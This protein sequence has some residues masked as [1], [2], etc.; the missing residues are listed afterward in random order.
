MKKDDLCKT[1]MVGKKLTKKEKKNGKEQKKKHIGAQMC[2][3]MEV[4]I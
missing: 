3:K 1:Q 4:N 2:Q